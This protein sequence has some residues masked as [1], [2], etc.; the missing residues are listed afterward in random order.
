M[1]VLAGPSG[2][3]K[4]AFMHQLATAGLQADIAEQLPPGAQTWAQIHNLLPHAKWLPT[5]ANSMKQGRNREI[6]LQ[7]DLTCRSFFYVHD[8]G[9]DPVLQLLPIAG[10]VLVINLRADRDRLIRQ[11][12]YAKMGVRTHREI[13]RK[14]FAWRIARCAGV[15]SQTLHRIS[16][17]AERVIA[18]M[19]LVKNATK[20]VNAQLLGVRD[21]PLTWL[22]AYRRPGGVE[23]IFDRWNAFLSSMAAQGVSV[24]QI[25]LEPEPNAPIA[26]RSNYVEGQ[27]RWRISRIA[28]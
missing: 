25:H 5:L 14:V 20:R 6:I 17:K 23:A 3:G 26:D 18:D 8:Y 11:W 13:R 4:S 21:N 24:R 22:H 10:D 16:P 7:Y 15:A 19:G 12:A 1:I 2:A 27:Y 9:R 28:S